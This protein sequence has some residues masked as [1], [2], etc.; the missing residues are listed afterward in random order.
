VTPKLET[1]LILAAAAGVAF[2]TSIVADTQDAPNAG[3]VLFISGIF[4]LSFLFLAV[5]VRRWAPAA[6]RVFLPLVALLTGVGIVEVTRLD[7]DLGLLQ[8]WW[9]LTGSAIAAVVL[10]LLRTRGVEVLRRFRYLFLLGAVLLLA[11]PLLPSRGPLQGVTINGSR[12]WVR[13]D[14]GSSTLSFQ[15]GEAAKLLV[16]VFL[17][18]YL[19]ER[20]KTLVQMRRSVGPIRIP[21]PRQLL[22]ILL[23][24]G[25]AFA[26]LVY[27]RDLGASLL[28]FA[29]FVAM[30]Y[31]ATDQAS[32]LLAG[33][34]FVAGGAI[35]ANEMFS[36]VQTRV[37]SWLHPFDDPAGAGYQMVQ[38]LFALGSG[39]VTGTGIGSGRPDLIPAAATDFIY[40]AVGEELGLAGTIA[41]LAGFA[42]LV[43][44]GF[45]IALRS[46][47]S[48]RTLLAAGLTM[49]L[50]VQTILIVSGVVRLFPI[51]G[52]ALP[53]LSYGGSALLANL[54][55]VAL[56]IRISHEERT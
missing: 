1:G 2:G 29:V 49:T 26:V 19:A 16:V 28:L 52:I 27:Q 38:S 46:G 40:A 33:G 48:F 11:L 35:A 12:L 23:A 42:L 7:P 5:A 4:L 53:F 22:P 50:A 44:A 31:A 30:L 13:V 10:F 21:E 34:V 36:H 14:L 41:V 9:L 20:G 25:I 39:G 54:V 18:S 17:A 15:P 56:L 6:T 51:T 24:A 47:N 55:L 32:Y 3:E 43:G 37:T 8:A 45:G